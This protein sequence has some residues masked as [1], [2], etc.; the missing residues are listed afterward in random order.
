[1]YSVC[2]L[3]QKI[4]WCVHT[5]I[6]GQLQGQCITVQQIECSIISLK[7]LSLRPVWVLLCTHLAGCSVC[8]WETLGKTLILSEAALHISAALDCPEAAHKAH[9]ELAVQSKKA[10]LPRSPEN[11]ELTDSTSHSMTTSRLLYH[12]VGPQ[13]ACQWHIF[14][15]RMTK[16][17]VFV[18]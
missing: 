3:S 17:C 15:D 12:S 16:L 5:L 1:M 10:G 6:P 18:R 13:N 14:V 8:P 11:R 9:W 4:H 7:S 2:I